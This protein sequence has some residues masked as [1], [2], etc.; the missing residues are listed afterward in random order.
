MRWSTKRLAKPHQG[1][2]LKMCAGGDPALRKA[3]LEQQVHHQLAVAWSVLARRLGP[4]RSLSSAGSARWAVKPRRRS[5]PRRKRQPVVP[6]RRSGRRSRTGTGPPLP[7]RSG[8]PGSLA[9]LQLPGA[10]VNRPERDLSPVQVQTAYHFHVGPPSSSVIDTACL[11]RLCR[12][13]PL[14]VIF[15]YILAYNPGI[16]SKTALRCLAGQPTRRLRLLV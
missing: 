2:Q 9:P 6:S 10:E 5:P 16:Y 8:H 1:A 7:H 11:T 12:E 14:H 13:A 15:E 3:A 4:R